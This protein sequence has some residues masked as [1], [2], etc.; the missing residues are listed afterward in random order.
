MTE[1]CYGHLLAALYVVGAV[2]NLLT[3]VVLQRR[4]RDRNNCLFVYII[5]F[6]STLVL[7]VSNSLLHV[8]L[9]CV[10]KILLTYLLTNWLL[11]AS[12]VVDSVYLICR[13]AV[14]FLRFLAC[15]RHV[16]CALHG[17]TETVI[18]DLD[19]CYGASKV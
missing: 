15:T 16:E 8:R 14:L 11:R 17:T 1:A 4:R 12:A 10:N 5:M 13:L 7:I 19:G 18:A 6:I 2:G 3:L 9:S